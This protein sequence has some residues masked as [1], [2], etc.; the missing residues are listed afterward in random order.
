M[1][2]GQRFSPFSTQFCLFS[3]NLYYSDSSFCR[4][5][6]LCCALEDQW[7][8]ATSHC[9]TAMA[10]RQY[11]PISHLLKTTRSLS[12]LLS[13]SPLKHFH[14]KIH[15]VHWNA[16]EQSVSVVGCIRQYVRLA[17][18]WAVTSFWT[19][20]YLML[21]YFILIPTWARGPGM[22]YA[23]SKFF[24]L[25]RAPRPTNQRTY[26]PHIEMQGRI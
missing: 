11:P 6:R 17:F 24:S 8:P 12:G 4:A 25:G 16:L 9:P 10:I 1:K 19:L 2:K 14:S 26:G 13:I 7:R 18:K 15:L 23:F 3:I 5:A 21:H 22:G 20:V